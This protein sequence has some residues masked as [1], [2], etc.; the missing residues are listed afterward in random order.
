MIATVTCIASMYYWNGLSSATMTFENM[1]WH[2]ITS[3]IYVATR[4]FVDGCFFVPYN[5]REEWR[6]W[7]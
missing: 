4:I 7:Q 2:F 1:K 5:S 6:Y 3:L